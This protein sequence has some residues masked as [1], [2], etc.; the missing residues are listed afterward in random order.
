MSRKKIL[1]AVSGLV[2][3]GLVLIALVVTGLVR[4]AFG[5]LLP[6]SRGGRAVGSEPPV[7]LSASERPTKSATPT[8]SPT[9]DPW[10]L[11]RPVLA[12]APADDKPDAKRLAK[13][14]DSVDR[15]TMKGT[16]SGVVASVGADDDLYRHRATAALIPASTTKLLTSV[17]ALSVLGPEHRFVTTV[18]SGTT[19]QIV[20]VGGGDPYLTKSAG[21]YPAKASLESLAKATAAALAKDN[22]GSVKL[23]Y[24]AS[25]FTGDSWNP[26]WPRGYSDQVSNVSAL[27]VDEGRVTGKSPGRR[28]ADPPA[29][30]AKDFAEA[31]EDAGVE[32]T[33]SPKEV[34]AGDNAAR[35]AQVSSLPLERIVEQVLMSSDNDGAEV[36]F[37]QA[38]IGL[39]R[40]GSF[41]GGR[42]A[43]QEQL[44]TLGVWTDG[45]ELH[46]G[47]GL[48]RE[49][50]ISAEALVGVLRLGASADHREL[51]GV[52]TGL[53]V[54]GVEGSLRS[55]Y[56]S[57]TAE[58]ARGLVR[59]KTG[60]LRKVH[61][62]AGF[63]RTPDG[64]MLAY[65]FVVN[66][67]EGDWAARVWLEEVSAALATCDC[68]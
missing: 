26:T 5:A 65:A 64:A 17:A 39:G 10:G 3:I 50:K 31:L 8:P 63:V 13:A 12:A 53:P 16:F 56:S 49:N 20:L 36:L 41:D 27:W 30:A 61:S 37:R 48:S 58:P 51:R 25:L 55:R 45:T 43:V 18:V 59:G 67:P 44:A 62:L 57:D 68:D 35:I 2:V 40:P 46:D 29:A 54:A 60:T 24:D 4:G 28:V 9:A 15:S 38:A 19:G 23:G 52:I 6:G 42:Q 21:G 32:I 11:P 14:I 47:S 66:H 33:G 34:D 22:V 7:V 1:A